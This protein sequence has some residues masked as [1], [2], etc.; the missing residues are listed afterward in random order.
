MSTEYAGTATY[1]ATVTLPDDGDPRNATTLGAALED[2]ADRT[3][4]LH[5]APDGDERTHASGSTDT[6]EAGSELVIEDGAL[7]TIEGDLV[8]A[9]SGVLAIAP[10]GTV[11]ENSGAVVNEGAT[12]TQTGPRTLSGAGRILWRVI[13]GADSNSVYSNADADVV[14]VSGLS[15]ARVYTL[16]EGGDTHG[17]RIRFVS[18]DTVNAVTFVGAGGATIYRPV[19]VTGMSLLNASDGCSWIEF[20]WSAGGSGRPAEGWYVEAYRR[21][22]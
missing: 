8:V 17:S 6:Y 5:D 22:P 15:D 18:L 10:G 2:L 20:I 12:Y 19:D 4:A 14:I 21:I 13:A 7:A 16:G 1:H 3:A 9:A 11:A